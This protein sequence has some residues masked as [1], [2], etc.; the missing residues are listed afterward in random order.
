MTTAQKARRSQ[1]KFP[2][3]PV[4]FGVVAVG[5]IT[6]VMLT[7]DNGGGGSDQFGSPTISGTPL[8]PLPQSG[9]DPA[10]GLAAPEVEGADFDGNQVSIT[11]DGTAKIILFL[12]HW[13]PHCQREVP[14]VQD[15]LDT[16]PLGSDV[17]FY[18]VATSINSTRDNYPPSSWLDREGWTPEVVV[19]DE[20]STIGNSFGLTAFP[21]WVFLDDSGAVVARVSGGVA[22][23]D[24][25]SAVALLAAGPPE[26]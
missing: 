18:S 16:E 21:Y 8:P 9:G 23:S 10:V 20:T 12:A 17:D 3:L 25:D 1:K 2:L 7:F 13:C 26:G 6:V 5:L 19:D 11:N 15:W 22:P 24:L 4:I 14:I